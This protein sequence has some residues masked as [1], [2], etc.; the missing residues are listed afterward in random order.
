MGLNL[1]SGKVGKCG[2]V[3]A[4]DGA[5]C[6][7]CRGGDDQVMRAPGP[8]LASDMYEQLGVDPRD[9]TVVV[10]DGNDLQDLVEEGKAS[11]TVLA[12]GQEHTNSQLGCGDGGD[13]NL[14][15]IGDG[16][17]EGMSR[18]FGVDEKGRVE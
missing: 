10:E 11:G 18:S 13:R 4:H 2:L 15:V 12:R 9:G 16:V 1:N 17:V 6:G 3:G 7:P 5:A 14:V 8:S